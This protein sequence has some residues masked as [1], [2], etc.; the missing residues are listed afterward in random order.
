VSRHNLGRLVVCRHLRPRR[1]RRGSRCC[2]PVTTLQTPCTIYRG[3]NYSKKP[4]HRGEK[5]KAPLKSRSLSATTCLPCMESQ[6]QIFS[7]SSERQGGRVNG[8]RR[9]TC[10]ERGKP[11]KRELK[12]IVGKQFLCCKI[13][14]SKPRHFTPTKLCFG[15][16]G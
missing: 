14:H 5:R 2:S 11:K 9:P 13:Q 4:K 12:L 10:F 8:Q 6:A 16:V 3:E 1:L 15:H 7:L